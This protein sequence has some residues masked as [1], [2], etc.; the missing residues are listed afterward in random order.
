MYSAIVK[1]DDQTW[2]IFFDFNYYSMVRLSALKTEWDKQLPITFMEVTSYK[3]T[4]I[5]GAS[6]DGS[7]FSGGNE[8]DGIHYKALPDT[9]EFWE[10][11]KVYG[12]LCDNALMAMIVT[13][14]DTDF[15]ELV[16]AAFEGEVQF[17]KHEG[18]PL[19]QSINYNPETR[20][21]S[22]A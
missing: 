3:N 21:S 11:H 7:S 1:N 15:A 6:W 16:A 22:L 2:D 4:A 5:I 8:L 9:E 18:I 14:N 10:S 20:E 17:I 12:F 13:T 19:G